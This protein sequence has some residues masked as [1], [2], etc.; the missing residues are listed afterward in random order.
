MKEVVGALQAAQAREL[1][2]ILRLDDGRV[3]LEKAQA[4]LEQLRGEL[5]PSSHLESEREALR[6][7]VRDLRTALPPIYRMPF[8]G[9]Y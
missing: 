9:E 5:T 7:E 6:H 2:Y 4:Q 8:A 3:A 1:E